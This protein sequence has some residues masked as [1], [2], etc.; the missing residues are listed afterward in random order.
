M[1]IVQPAFAL[2]GCNEFPGIFIPSSSGSVNQ[3][4]PFFDIGGIA[5]PMHQCESILVL[6]WRVALT[7]RS[8]KTL[9][10]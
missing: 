9:Y 7:S 6:A 5:D 4:H 3:A 2:R 10:C 1:T 8:C